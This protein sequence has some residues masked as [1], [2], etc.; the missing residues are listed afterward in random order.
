[1]DHVD[2]FIGI[3]HE[4]HLQIAP[5]AVLSPD[6]PLIV[7]A[8]FGIGRSSVPNDEF[9]LLCLNAMLADMVK[10]PFVPAELDAHLSSS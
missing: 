8:L 2:G 7:P 3:Q 4:N 5:A 10:V 9:G 6:T 1:M